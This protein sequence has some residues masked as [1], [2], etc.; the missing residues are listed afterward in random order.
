MSGTDHTVHEFEEHGYS[1][2]EYKQLEQLYSGTMGKINAGEIIKGRVVHIGDSNV[3]VDIGFK[4][5]GTVPKNE[6]PN[7]KDL[8]IGDEIEVFLESIEDKDGQLVLSRKRA[9]FMRV[10]ERVVKSHDTGEVLKGRCVRRTKGGIVVDLMGLDAF[11]PGSQIDVRPVR[12]FDIFIGREMDFR[13]VKVNHPSENVVVSHKVLVEEELSS[14]RK[15][16]LDSLEKGQ[17]LEGHVKAITDFGVFVDLGGVDGLV[18]ITDLSWGRVNHPSEIVKLDQLVNI[19]VLDFDAEKK[20]ISLGMKQLQPHPWENIDQRY[21][22]GTKISGKIVSLTDYGAFVEIEK[23][24]EGLIHISE[25]SWTQHIKH[26][27]QV[28]SMGQV[29]DAIILSLDKEGKKISLGMK[30]LEP[31]PWTTL[32]QKY[33]IGSKHVGTVRNLT[34]FGVFVELEEGVDGLVH[35]SDLSWTKKIRHP[36]EVVKKGD[37]LDVIVLSVDISQRRISL[38][39]KQV[40]ENP[41]EVFESKYKVG[42]DVEGNVVRII[43]KGVI[44]EMPLGVD[45]FVPLSQ[46]SHTPVKNIAESFKVGDTLPLKV[47]EFDKESKKI[48]L[49]ALEYL[50]G[51]EQKLVDD[52]VAGHKLTPMTMKDVVSAPTPEEKMIDEPLAEGGH[53]PNTSGS[54]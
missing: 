37:Q 27:S 45:G 19:V 3:A 38:G 21:P 18:H 47:I 24:I 40:Q 14:Q 10:W 15:T 35:I 43:E 44:V 22:V 34:N 17:I 4:S 33:P 25:M 20:R 6:F 1:E 29:T 13:V 16:I 28:V 48:V 5:E 51:K 53:E 36:G 12:D 7:I 9:D 26:P 31:D 8:K 30:Q 32:M 2:E 49:S 42:T 23:G 46:L 41:W 52:Y 39:H 54:N 50:R 11:L